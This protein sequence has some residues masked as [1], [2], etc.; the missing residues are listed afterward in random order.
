M[1]EVPYFLTGVQL[2][3]TVHLRC[4]T[5]PLSPV[6]Q[7]FQLRFPLHDVPSQALLKGLWWTQQLNPTKKKCSNI[8]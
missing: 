3:L 1:D 7:F 4:S 2:C 6:L 8:G 5:V